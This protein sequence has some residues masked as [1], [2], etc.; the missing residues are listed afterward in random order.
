MA[1][2]RLQRRQHLSIGK[3]N[4]ENMA[5]HDDQLETPLRSVSLGRRL[6]PLDSFRERFASGY[7]EHRHRWFN[8]NHPVT[9]H[10]ESTAERA[11][12]AAQVEHIT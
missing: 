6:N 7:R 4:L 3:K 1:A 12:T 8:T 10:R 5:G 2:H 11:C 9:T